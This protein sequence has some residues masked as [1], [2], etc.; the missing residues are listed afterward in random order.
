MVSAFPWLLEL[1]Q[2][3]VGHR[4]NLPKFFAYIGVLPLPL[5]HRQLANRR[6]ARRFQENEFRR[7]LFFCAHQ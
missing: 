1:L 2:Q 4:T 3:L 6:E 7:A 5:P